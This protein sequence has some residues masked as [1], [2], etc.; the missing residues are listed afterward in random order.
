MT[1]RRLSSGK[2]I[3]ECYPNGKNGTRIRK[4]F[5]TKGEAMAFE[6][7]LVPK[8]TSNGSA[9]QALKLSELVERWYEMHGKTLES[10]HSRKSKLDAICMRLN[11][12]YVTEFDKNNAMLDFN[13]L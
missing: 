10:G 11:N 1:V 3:C 8:D 5:A 4:Q 13:I 9:K 6:R 12:P 2:W 7:K